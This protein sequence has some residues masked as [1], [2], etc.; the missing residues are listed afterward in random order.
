M[1]RVIKAVGALLFL[2]ALLV[3]LP[4]LLIATVGNPW[5]AGGLDELE[6]MTNSAVLGLISVLGVFF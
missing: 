2:T 4:A 5:P 3:G 6:M 1:V